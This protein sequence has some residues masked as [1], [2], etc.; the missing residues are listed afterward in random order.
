MRIYIKGLKSLGG[1]NYIA[2]GKKLTFLVGPNSA[3]KSVLLMA[4]D[5]LSGEWINR[6]FDYD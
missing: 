5:K 1:E 6:E 4:L 3:G 2:L